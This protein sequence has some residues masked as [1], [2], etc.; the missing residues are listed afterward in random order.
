MKIDL[1]Q[2]AARANP[3]RRKRVVTIRDTPMPA[4][5]ASDLYA[6]A[7]RPVVALIERY[8][9]LAA[10]EYERSLSALITDSADDLTSIFERMGQE[11]ASLVLLLRPSLRDWSVKVERRSRS[12]WRGAVLTASQVDLDTLLG[13]QDVETTLS[14][15]LNWN[16]ALVKDVGEQ[17]RGKISSAVFAGLRARSPAREVA[18]QIKEATGFARDRSLRI[19]SHQLSSL[20]S[21]LARERREQAGLSVYMWRHSAKLH[22]RVEH[23]ARNGKLYSSDASMVGREVDGKTVNEDV[24]ANDRCGIRPFCGCREQSVLVFD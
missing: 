14:D 11:L 16:V 4:V 7:Y 15:V 22:P 19:A 20:S 13:P 9:T 17:A 21:S 23:L 10:A 18:A 24:P 8:A 5:L 3:G 6:S 12:A 2:M 1:K